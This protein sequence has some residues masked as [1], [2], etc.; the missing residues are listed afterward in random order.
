ME[1]TELGKAAN[2]QQPSHVFDVFLSYSRKDRD[3][4]VKLENALE[5]YRPPKNLKRVKRNLN[6][7]RDEADIEASEDYYRTIEKHLKGSAKLVVICS[8]DARNSKYIEDEIRR[9]MEV[10]GEKDIIPVLVRGK[11]NNET[12]DESEK[13]FPD[14]LCE[15]RMPLAASFLG[16]NVKDK[17]DKSQ[18]RSSWYSILSAIYGIDRRKLEQIDEKLRARKRNIALGATVAIT[19]VLSVSLVF[20]LISRWEAVK[21]RENAERRRNESISSELSLYSVSLLQSDPELSLILALKAAQ[22]QQTPQSENA[23]RLALVKAP[24]HVLHTLETTGNVYMNRIEAT[25]SPDGKQILVW[26]AAVNKAQV[27]DVERGRKIF[28][29]P[30]ETF[31]MVASYSPDGKLIVTGSSD[32]V[33]TWD[34]TTGSRLAEWKVKLE[35]EGDYILNLHISPDSKFLLIQGF[36]ASQ[37]QVVEISSGRVVA[38]L[39]GSSPVFSHDGKAV[40]TTGQKLALFDTQSWERVAQIDAMSGAFSPDDKYILA[41]S[42]SSRARE[43]LLDWTGH[44]RWYDRQSVREVRS[45]SIS[46]ELIAVKFSPHGNLVAAT[47]S[48]GLY[49]WDDAKA[50]SLRL[51]DWSNKKAALDL[52]TVPISFSPDDRFLLSV[53]DA[54]LLYDVHSE[55]KRVVAELGG[56]RDVFTFNAAFSPDGKYALTVNHDGTIFV[57]DLNIWRGLV[58]RR[59]EQRNFNT[60][61]LSPDSK[62]I[63]AA[64]ESSQSESETQVRVWKTENGEA[65][66]TFSHPEM[67]NSI[68][69]SPDGKLLIIVGDD[70]SYIWELSS[71]RNLTILKNEEYG[72][73]ENYSSDGK[74][75]V[76]SSDKG[77]KVWDANSRQLVRDLPMGD[78]VD[79]AVFSPDSKLVLIISGAAEHLCDLTGKCSRVMTREGADISNAL[80][81]PDGKLILNVR[82]DDGTDVP[83][84]IDAQTG[85][86]VTELTGHTDWIN[87]ASFSPDGKYVMLTTG[88]EGNKDTSPSAYDTV[89]VVSV[90]DLS[91]GSQVYQFK[92]HNARMLSGTFTP[93]GQSIIVFANDGTLLT[94]SC[95]VC[96]PQ[97]KLIKLAL[98]RNLRDLTLDER[99]RY[100]HESPGQ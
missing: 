32:T 9:F 99:V 62:F 70:T 38:N 30:R 40:L 20:A 7:F 5:S 47:T 96:V 46:G 71:G 89:N 77:A 3:F 24:L 52:D 35:R 85:R 79:H 34:A 61:A 45:D 43:G 28:E 98:A 22:T 4:A 48:K 15:N 65:V 57:W 51:A 18:F 41:G 78:H 64:E 2:S 58:E 50:P 26:G 6:V 14:I 72:E 75:F 88:S 86:L 82:Q 53:Y 12:T 19:L 55:H 80:F 27:W 25:F 56:R 87:S 66:Q 54:T 11:A 33:R 29:I 67:V 84:V 59:L 60:S 21:A 81:S 1:S 92:G 74:F 44:L 97:D 76:T 63:A 95:G 13:A 73:V 69:F 90:W 93:D 68:A 10:H 83:Q 23:L 42:N 39:E 100:L 31:E 16:C 17:L 94:Y 36:G 49:L 8:P 37:V 91:S